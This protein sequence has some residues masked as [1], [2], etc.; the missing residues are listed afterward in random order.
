MLVDWSCQY[1]K[2]TALYR[3]PATDGQNNMTN[4]ILKH[5]IRKV[6]FARNSA[7]TSIHPCHIRRL[8]IDNRCYFE[9]QPAE[10]GIM[11]VLHRLE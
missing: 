9:Q 11:L 7:M 8:K 6:S 10:N 4:E 1:N 3:R 2:A 5:P